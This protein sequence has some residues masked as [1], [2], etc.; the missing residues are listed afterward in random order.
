M[1]RRPKLQEI[2]EDI[3]QSDKVY[4]QP[5]PSVHLTY[6]CIIYRDNIISQRH[7]NNTVYGI[8]RSYTVTFITRE[9]DDPVV[10]K[11]AWLPKCRFERAFTNDNL[12]HHVFRIYE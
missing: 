2:L 8:E 3:L 12:Y 10:E 5:P 6:P 9:H 4:Y 7:A 11:L 1:A